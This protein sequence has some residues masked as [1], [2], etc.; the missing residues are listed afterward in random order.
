MKKIAYALIATLLITN[1]LTFTPS[2]EI[3]DEQFTH[4]VFAEEFTATWCVY[5]PSAAENLMLVYEDAPG[6]PYYDDNFFFVAL[7]TDVNDKADDRMGDFP[8][9]TGY[10]TVIFDGNDEKV[11]GGQSNTANFEQAID[12]TG[13]RDDT[14]ISLEIEMNHLGNDKLRISIGMTWNED[15]SFSNPTFNGYVRA[16]IVEKISRYNNYDGDPYHFG[17]LDYAFDQN[18]E[19]EPREKQS[20]NTIWTGGDHQDKNGNDFSDIDYNNINVFVAFFNDESTASDKYSLQ[21][22]FAIPPVIEVASIEHEVNNQ[23]VEVDDIAGGDL[24]IRGLAQSEKSEINELTYRWNNRPWQSTG[25]GNF[26]GEFEVTID[27]TEVEN[28]LNSLEI[29]TEN[30]GASNT[31][32]I[33]VNVLNDFENPNIEIIS[34]YDGDTINEITVFEVVAT[35]DNQI[36]KVQFNVN[37][38]E[39][40]TMYSSTDDKYIASWNT[41]EADAGNGEHI[42]SFKAT[43]KSGN[44][45]TQTINLTVFNE[46][47]VTYP[48]LKI[49][50]PEDEIY[51]SRV[52][53]E[54][55]TNDPEGIKSVEYKVDGN[56][57]KDM[58]NQNGNIF[59]T[60]W[61]PYTDGWHDLLIRSTDNQD[62]STNLSTI[63]ETDSNPP[64]INLNS[65]TYD[66]SATAKFDIN[67]EDYSDLQSLRYRIDGMEWINL[68]ETLYDVSFVW[69]STKHEDGECLIE[70]ECVDKWGATN[71]IYKNVKV[72]NKGLINSV[73]PS[74]IQTNNV[75]EISAIIDYESPKSVNLVIAKFDSDVLSEG[76]KLP[77]RKEG[78]YYYGDL[79]FEDS[80]TYVYSIEIDTGHGKLKSYEQNI[81][82][83]EEQTEIVKKDDESALV[84]L[85]FGPI[86]FIIIIIAARKK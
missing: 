21:S 18:V 29:K 39:L 45:Q 28:G 2:A 35:D 9:V 71:K 8:D 72:K 14:D 26:N 12:T 22:A 52:K 42:L 37:N 40:R 64:Y 57:W 15:G 30:T 47:D 68:D 36:D 41:Q 32:L 59:A 55:Q 4:T 80:G 70:I 79:Y 20:L 51:N 33:E 3:S 46:G 83:T 75:I 19:L 27:T 43:D 61:T 34:H 66:V 6:E 53:I 74:N 60:Y 65:N 24:R 67:V 23:F 63:F 48:S 1:F 82:V 77:M 31:K 38:G 13:Q 7:I 49:I 54:V 86:V 81:L 69:D 10:P 44:H 56:D 11:S 5:C 25:V 50:L 85:N 78:D 17:F 84:S 62:Y 76:Q 73:A 16:Y 58:D